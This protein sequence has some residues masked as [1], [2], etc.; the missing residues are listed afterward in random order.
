MLSPF[1]E[2]FFLQ[3]PNSFPILLYFL[4]ELSYFTLLISHYFLILGKFLIQLNNYCIEGCYLPFL[5]LL[6]SQPTYFHFLQRLAALDL[7]LLCLTDFRLQ[8]PNLFGVLLY[9]LLELSNSPI[10]AADNIIIF[11]CLFLNFPIQLNDFCVQGICLFFLLL[12]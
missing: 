12:L 3:I 7:Y 11:V 2:Y 5:F 1:L 10:F 9:C 6:E 4:F 8:L